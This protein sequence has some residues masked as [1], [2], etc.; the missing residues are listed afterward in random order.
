MDDFKLDDFSTFGR[1]DVCYVT[2]KNPIKVSL[3]PTQPESRYR[4]LQLEIGV[5]GTGK[6][7]KTVFKNLNEVAGMMQV[8]PEFIIK[9]IGYETS[10]H[11]Y[12]KD[13]GIA[14]NLSV[15]VLNDILRKFVIEVICCDKCLKP[16]IRFKKMK[17]ICSAC[18]SRSPISGSDKFLNFVSKYLPGN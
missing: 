4:T 1:T 2:T 16:E 12:P 15:A 9:F 6:M 7:I 8:P 11:V 14:G 5:K 17:K 13:N 10:S 18:G 3:D